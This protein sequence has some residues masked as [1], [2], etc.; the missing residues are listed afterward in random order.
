MNFFLGLDGLDKKVVEDLDCKSLLQS[1]HGALEVPINPLRGV[2]MTPEVWACFL[3]GKAVQSGLDFEMDYK[4]GRL[5]KFVFRSLVFLRKHIHLSLGLGK[6]LNIEVHK[7]FPELEEK[8]FF[9]FAD[10]FGFN[11][12]YHNHDSTIFMFNY[13]L[14]RKKMKFEEYKREIYNLFEERKLQ[15]ISNVSNFNKTTFVYL[16]FPD[17]IQH[18]E[19]MN[20]EVLNQHYFQLDGFVK[21]LKSLFDFDNFVIVSDHGFDFD[22][23]SHSKEGFYSLHKELSFKPKSITDFYNVI[24]GT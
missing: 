9:D 19:F 22:N 23:A 8:T 3:T 12:P 16:E 10:V 11:V 4:M 5:G 14:Y 15:V 13:L 17:I 2:P 1:E 7:G 24:V 20:R 21:H 6:A 18:I